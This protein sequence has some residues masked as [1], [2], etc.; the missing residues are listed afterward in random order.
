[1]ITLKQIDLS[2]ISYG[3]QHR[4]SFVA[5]T[6][7]DFPALS[8]IVWDY[9]VTP[10]LSSVFIIPRYARLVYSSGSSI[11]TDNIDITADNTFITVDMAN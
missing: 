1:M 8:V 5:I 3:E 7:T 6:G 10:A 2:Q 9:D 4:S 11:T